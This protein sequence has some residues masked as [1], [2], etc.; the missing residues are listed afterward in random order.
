MTNLV[1]LL[2]DIYH[3]ACKYLKVASGRMN[4]GLIELLDPVQI[5]VTLIAAMLQK[6]V[7]SHCLQDPTAS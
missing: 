5:K 4:L 6:T 7:Q 2:H 1:E 3:N